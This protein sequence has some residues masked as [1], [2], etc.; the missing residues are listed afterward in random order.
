MREA[1]VRAGARA[2]ALERNGARRARAS[3]LDTPAARRPRVFP[4]RRRANAARPARTCS[5]AG[6][7]ADTPV[8]W[9]PSWSRP[10]ATCRRRT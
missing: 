5:G 7:R 3:D 4:R 1:P 10:C 6:R 9:R 8:S 2:A